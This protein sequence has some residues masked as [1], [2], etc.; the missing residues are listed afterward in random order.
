MKCI[1]VADTTFA[2]VDMGRF[3]IDEIRSS[4]REVRI[5]RYTVPGVKDLPAAAKRLFDEG[6]D[7]VMALGMPGAAE[8]DKQCANQASIGII[9]VQVLTGRHVI[10]V[11]VHEDEAEKREEL[12]QMAEERTRK[13]AVNA[14]RLL[15]N[16][17]ELT[18]MA[19]TGRRQGAPDAGPLRP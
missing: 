8:I 13:H 7:L 19:G 16:P 12:L 14:L 17:E 18:R 4:G 1:G 10:E 6:C 11:F 9:Q 3:A 2:R 5:T 15:F